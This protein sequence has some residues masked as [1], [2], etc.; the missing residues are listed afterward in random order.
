MV[1]GGAGFLG[2]YVCDLLRQRPIDL[3]VPRHGDYDL[4]EQQAVR[5]LMADTRPDVV[6]HLAAEVGGIGA[7]RANPG[8]YFYANATMGINVIEESRRAGVEKLVQLGT[9]CA[10]PKCTP[11]PFREEDLWNGYPEETNAPYGIAKKSLLVMLQAYR[12]Q[13]DFNGI[14]L[15]PVNLY[16][17]GDNFDLETSHVIPALIRKFVDAR[18]TGASHVEV[19]GTGSASRE[20]LYVGDAARAIVLATEGYE[21]SA[22][23]NIGSGR[24]VAIRDLVALIADLTGYEGEIRW[25]T[26]KPDGQPRRMLNT[27]RAKEYFGF[28]AQVDLEEGLR[29]TITWW[30]ERRRP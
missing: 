23:V 9:V 24:E 6:L 3:V 27:V 17:P 22:P 12:D 19:W 14:Y 26:T 15:L 10:Y 4:T 30:Q 8:R 20:F 11:V 2:T 18:E 13:Y 25:D 28:E 16:G 1:T 21:G 5:A 29:R 7:N